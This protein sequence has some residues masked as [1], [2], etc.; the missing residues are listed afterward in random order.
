MLVLLALGFMIAQEICLRLSM[1]QVYGKR[2][3]RM[4]EVMLAF[5]VQA[6]DMLGGGLRGQY[7]INR[8][9]SWSGAAASAQRRP[10]APAQPAQPAQG[11]RAAVSNSRLPQQRPRG[12]PTA[13]PSRE[14]PKQPEQAVHRASD[15]RAF[16]ASD[17]A[18]QE[19]SHAG[20]AKAS[21]K[22]DARY[23]FGTL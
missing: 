20:A 9:A 12:L 17:L 2:L 22:R 23:A 1:Q 18:F 3:L 6:L 19:P 5:P 14:V 11:S 15:P 13:L 21:A 16:H 7:R 8:A 10:E 4:T